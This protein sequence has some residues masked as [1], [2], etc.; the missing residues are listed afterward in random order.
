MKSWLRWTLL[1]T[2]AVLVGLIL[3]G[4]HYVLNSA[5]LDEAIKEEVPVG[6]AKAQVVAFIQKRH[7]VAY[8]DMGTEVKARLQGLAENMV[9]RK[10]IVVTFK[11]SPDGKLLSYAT[12]EYLTFL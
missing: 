11:F 12:K 3:L 8:D 5:K 2:G 1:L 4:R 9:Y 7:P 6:S 10:D